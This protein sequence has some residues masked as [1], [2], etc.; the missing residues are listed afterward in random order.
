MRNFHKEV[1]IYLIPGHI[2]PPTTCPFVC[3]IQSHSCIPFSR[4]SNLKIPIHQQG[5]CKSK[6]QND[7]IKSH[8]IWTKLHASIYVPISFACGHLPLTAHSC[9]SEQWHLLQKRADISVECCFRNSRIA[10]RW[11]LRNQ[12]LPEPFV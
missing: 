1:S 6:Q 8:Q 9:I 2:V 12:Q 3:A 5:H 4:N 11:C 10:K 7:K